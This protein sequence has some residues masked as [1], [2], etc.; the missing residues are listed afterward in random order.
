L[1]SFNDHID[2]LLAIG[3]QPK[4]IISKYCQA[5]RDRCDIVEFA[6]LALLK[7]EKKK[8]KKLVRT[9]TRT[10]K[11]IMKETFKMATTSVVIVALMALARSLVLE[12]I[13]EKDVY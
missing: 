13:L 1:I 6:E 10:L 7:A 11:R 8:L 3:F 12:T 4:S 5:T 9:K 2:R